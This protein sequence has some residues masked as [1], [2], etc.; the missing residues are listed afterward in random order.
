M[1][2]CVHHLVLVLFLILTLIL[3]HLEFYYVL[4][5][6]VSFVGGMS[7]GLVVRVTFPGAISVN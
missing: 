2:V 6:F 1:I 3:F 5:Y 4:F 7:A